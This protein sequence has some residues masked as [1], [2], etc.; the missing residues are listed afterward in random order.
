M[1]PFDLLKRLLMWIVTLAI[2][3]SGYGLAKL[4]PFAAPRLL[5]MTA[6]DAAIPLLPWTVWAY[7]TITWASLLCWLSVP[8]QQQARR[9]FGS[10]V[11]ACMVCWIFFLFWPT[12]FPRGDWPLPEVDSATIREFADLRDADSPTNC[13]PSMH[14][15]MA[16]SIAL[17]WMGF[18][19][20]R[21]LRPLPL[22][23]AAVVSVTTLTTK[24]HYAVDVL[25]GWLAGLAAVMVA[26]RLTRPLDA[27]GP[28][29]RLERE[30]DR[31]LVARMRARV[32]AHQWSLDDLPWPEGPLPPLDPLMARLIGHII[33]IEEIAGL[34]FQ[35]QRDASA[36]PDLRALYQHFAD[37]ERRHA[38]GLRRVLALHG[39]ALEPPGLGNAL[40]LDQFDTLRPHHPADATLVALSTPVFET[41][42]DAGT[43]PFL[44]SH[45]QLASPAFDAFVERVNTDEAQHIALN[46]L[47]SR[48]AARTTPG[49]RSLGLLLNPAI[50]RGMLAV[51]WMSLDVYAVAHRLGYR[52]ETLLPAFGRLWRLHRRFPELGRYAPWQLFRL[53]VVCGVVATVTCVVAARL[54]VLCIGLWV[55]VSRATD[56]ISWALFGE[57][58]LEKRG[59]AP[60]GGINT[61]GFKTAGTEPDTP[62]RRP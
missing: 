34:N 49:W 20:T 46:W 18:I 2:C 17:T 11:L 15:A 8:N 39:A 16:S 7:G 38:D 13:F 59:L 12:T 45:P 53:F 44:R 23:W 54:R 36:D 56:A 3:I 28:P 30:I 43:I 19:R 50:F 57:R 27:A 31:R 37:E 48:Q 1:S 10:L 42:L 26:R 21:W 51:P 40:V 58:L 52:F 22:L 14:V 25:G 35:F 32:A 61:A 62:R 47:L 33:Y 60:T 6:L 5:P 29:L 55:R 41:F 9:L 24:Q 4:E